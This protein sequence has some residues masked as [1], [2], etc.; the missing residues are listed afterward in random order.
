VPKKE[1]LKVRMNMAD[2]IACGIDPNLLPIIM[3]DLTGIE[4]RSDG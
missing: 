3:K 2:S 4:Y 1:R